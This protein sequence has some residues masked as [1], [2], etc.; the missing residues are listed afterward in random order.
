MLAGVS[1]P[2]A[3]IAAGSLIGGYLVARESGVRPLGGAVLAAGG[4]YL[5]DRWRKDAGAPA[6][7]FLLATYLGAFGISQPVAR[8]IAAWRSGLPVA[9]LTAGA[10]APVAD[11]R[12][13]R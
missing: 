4:I 11:R 10:S 9:A 6:A 8:R 5:A 7:G 1:P 12:R 13:A 2:T 3:P